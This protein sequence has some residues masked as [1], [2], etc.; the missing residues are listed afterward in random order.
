MFEHGV[1]AALTA[2]VLLLAPSAAALEPGE[3]SR[4]ETRPLDPA[5]DPEIDFY[6]SHWKESMPRSSH[7]S[8]V[9]RD[10]FTPCTGDIMHPVRRGAVLTSLSR[11]SR[12]TLAPKTST[13]P[14][15]L[16][17][18]QEI[19]Y[20]ESGRGRIETPASAA[21][22]HPGVGV[23]VPPGVGFTMTNTGDETLA[24]YLMVEPVPDGFKPNRDI[25]V[26][27]ENELPFRTSSVHWTHIA[28]RL[29]SREDGLATLTG[30]GPVWFDS[31]TM[32]QPHS[33]SEGV[34]EI[35]FALEGD[36]RIMLGKEMREFP[37]GTAYKIPPDSGTPH[38]TINVTGGTVKTFWM[39]RN[40][41]HNPEPYSQLDPAPLD[42]ETE[43]D[44]DMFIGNYRES[45]PRHVRGSLI[46][47]DVL[48]RSDGDL[49]RPP[50]K[51]A[52][53]A[54]YNRFVH[55][56][57]PAHSSTL[58]HTPKGEQEL[59]YILTGEGILTGGGETFGLYPGVTFLV[60]E[61]LEFSMTCTGDEPLTM[62]IVAEPTYPGFTPVKRIVLHDENTTH[63]HTSRAHWVYSN[64]YLVEAGEGLAE[65]QLFLTVYVSPNTFG[66]PH[67]H[68]DK[69]EEVWCPIDGD[70]HILLGKEVRKLTPGTAYKV[71][72]DGSTP[73]ANFNVSDRPVRMFYF[74]RFTDPSER[75]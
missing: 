43:P 29:F 55:A 1:C 49:L 6:F 24:L 60:P 58:P 57:L 5:I 48:S 72:P 30:M 50:A 19:F 39:M 41:G 26:R 42:P 65:T 32:G 38:A 3:E 23:L 69:V 9:E 73:H 61:N 16:T 25:L 37:P 10:I 36:T 33:H 13:L 68:G 71:P 67:S 59:C 7:G 45:M 40:T 52:V 54:H 8:L 20:V 46:E 56:M 4:L 28:K 17:G 12:A 21:E 75:K 63:L 15:T 44:I 31:M 27:D 47:R 2:V 53:L 22:L 11:F 64:K 70:V 74:A 51:G 35:W 66:H 62:Y 18:E 14:T 34:E